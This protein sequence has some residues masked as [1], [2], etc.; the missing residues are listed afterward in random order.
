M[1]AKRFSIFGICLALGISAGWLHAEPLLNGLAVNTE[2]GKERF[3]AALYADDLTTNAQTML[4]STRYRRME[5]KVT[6][7]SLS[8]RSVNSM[9]V[10]GM[11]I[12]NPGS[13]LEAEADNLAKL[14]NMIRR[15][16]REGD[17]LT[18]DAPPGEGMAVSLNGV[19]LGTI[20]SPN[21][22]TMV[23]RT[24]IGSIPLSSDF[25]DNLLAAGDVDRGLAGRYATI[26]PDDARVQAVAGW[27]TP[28]VP[29]V[30]ADTGLTPPKPDVSIPAPAQEKKPEPKVAAA[31]PKPEPKPEPKPQ[32]KPAKPEPK[33][34]QVARATPPEPE[35][36]EV[37]EV[38]V[39]A[40]SLLLRQR[41]I[42][43]VMRATLQ[44]MRYPRR[45][46]ERAQE[47][48]IRLAVT[49]SR[50]GKVLNVQIVDES[51]HSLLNKEAVASVERAAPFSALPDGIAGDTL[52][53]GI[54]VTFRLQ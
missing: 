13:A 23:L 50:D 40:Q 38:M 6:A 37:E 22:F 47:G 32:P 7:P 53:F 42:S 45:A 35:D 17:V 11:A 15:R 5:L 8:A 24:W 4:D 25:K 46:L 28:A 16:L 39:T 31:P 48:S 36:D 34:E 21:F 19:R 52:A 12:N 30:T 54:P 18:F 1:R 14:N 41:Y 20:N 51:R 44:S 2:F 29:P 43:D 3:I 33:P 9:W 26:E 10:E 49:V 27:T